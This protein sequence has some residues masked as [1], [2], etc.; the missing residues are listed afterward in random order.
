M[1]TIN[2]HDPNSRFPNKLR[3]LRE[4][5]DE[6]LCDHN[7]HDHGICLGCHKDITQDLVMQ[8]EYRA[9]AAQDR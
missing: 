4:D 5:E 6:E 8:A 2:T 9:D 7:E 3:G 1:T